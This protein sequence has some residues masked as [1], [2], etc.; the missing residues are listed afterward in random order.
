MRLKTVGILLVMFVLCGCGAIG[1]SPTAV[2]PT[3][4]LDASKSGGTQP[5]SPSLSSGTVA[6]S[7]VVAPAQDA[8]LALSLGG[9]VKSVNVAVGDSVQAGK[10][11]V[12]LD[13]AAILMAV[14]QADRAIKEFTSPSAIAAAEQA[15]ANAQKDVKDTQDKVTNLDWPRA[16][17][18]LI[19]NTQGDIDLAKQALSRAT[20]AYSQ[21]RSLEDGEPRK[22]AALV[23]MTNAQM[24]L[25]RLQSTMNWYTGKPTE[26]DAAIIRANLDAAK[27]N[28]Q[29]AQWYLAVLKGEPIPDNAAGSKLAQLAQAK[30]N[31]TTAK[32]NLENSRLIAP[33]S[34]TVIAVNVVAGEMATPGEVLVVISDVNRLHIETTDLSERDVPQVKTGQVVSVLIKPLNLTVPGK[35]TRISALADTLGGDVVYKT[36][37]DLDSPPPGMR[38]GMSVEVSFKTE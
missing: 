17:D 3:V 2:V 35:V 6:A 8:H 25:N 11:L 32:R 37:I 30:D 29:E 1:N 33:I 9:T 38:A 24:E 21:V 10:L 15:V 7:G 27:A 5:T 19:K 34:G 22:A 23:A 4:V 13:N 18:V 31:L 12:E 16:S 36:T 20:E 28:L 14:D 26:I